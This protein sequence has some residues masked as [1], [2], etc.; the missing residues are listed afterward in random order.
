MGLGVYVHMDFLCIDA[1]VHVIGLGPA[2]P[3][4]SEPEKQPWPKS[5]LH[6]LRYGR[7]PPVLTQERRDGAETWVL[8][9]TSI[10][11]PTLTIWGPGDLG[12]PRAHKKRPFCV[13]R[14]K[15]GCVPTS[16]FSTKTAEKELTNGT[17]NQRATL[18]H[19]RSKGA[20]GPLPSSS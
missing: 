1:P 15:R 20:C 13:A 8:Y 4:H 10:G 17:S 19:L 9:S 3:L 11:Y 16:I 2:P 7:L 6:K 5:T 14:A 18:P 12:R